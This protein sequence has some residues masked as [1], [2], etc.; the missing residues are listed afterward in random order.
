MHMGKDNV[1]FIIPMYHGHANATIKISR[2]L[3]NKGFDVYYAGSIQ[4]L[5]F[6]LKNKFKLFTL[7][8]TPIH[9]PSLKHLA[10]RGIKKWLDVVQKNK[11]FND[12]LTR[13][14]ELQ[15]LIQ[16][17]QPSVIFLDE[18]CYFDYVILSSLSA[19][20]NIYLLQGKMG[21]YY[22]TKN[23]PGNFY[24]FPNRFSKSLWKFNL[25]KNRL[26]RI[27]RNFIFAGQT[28]EGLSKKILKA[29][30]VSTTVKFNYN[31][32][33]APSFIGVPELLLYPPEFDFPDNTLMA[34]QQY[35]PSSVEL[36][37][38]EIISDNLKNFIENRT[39]E[40]ANRIIYCSLGTLTDIH[41][42]QTTLKTEFIHKC[43]QI[44]ANNPNYFFIISSGDDLKK[45]MDNQILMDNVLMVNF[46]PQL[47][48]L[49]KADLFLTHGGPN[50]VFEGIYTE[51]P[52]L[53]FPLNNKWDQ[54]GAA[55]RV[56]YHNIGIKAN[57][58]DSIFKIEAQISTLLTDQSYKESIAEM[59]KKIKQK[60]TDGYFSDQLDKIIGF[61]NGSEKE[62]K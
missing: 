56:V 3:Q 50:S 48:T 53:V 32:I 35:L 5:R 15:I 58:T 38:K 41:L 1:V 54:N 8:T 45:D 24:S 26:K 33:F 52:M 60:Y 44:A 30:Q 43:L 31:K 40:P 27:K 57:I 12:Y 55:A 2:L 39:L 16:K 28:L 7:D 36:E 51:T 61:K 14:N 37:R 22:N 20:L 25:I 4:L 59:A 34:W 23:P 17:L 19:N 18:F 21:M 10:Q 11:L 13:K 42:L 46:V 62:S 9:E 49:N 6:T 29:E 47:F